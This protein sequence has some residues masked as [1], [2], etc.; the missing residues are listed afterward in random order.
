MQAPFTN[1]QGRNQTLGSL[2]E[3]KMSM[4]AHSGWH[5]FLVYWNWVYYSLHHFCHVAHSESI[6]PWNYKEGLLVYNRLS[7]ELLWSQGD[8]FWC[9][10]RLSRATLPAPQTRGHDNALRPSTAQVYCKCVHCIRFVLCTREGAAAV[11]SL[12]YEG[13]I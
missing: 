1:T 3:Q 10:L 7:L 5:K 12:R 11:L 9:W 8:S 6:V 4:H 2:R 13:H